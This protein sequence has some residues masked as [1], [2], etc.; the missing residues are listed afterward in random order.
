MAIEA[1]LLVLLCR[2][3]TVHK[4][5]LL[6]Q[7]NAFAG[8]FAQ[9]NWLLHQILELL[10]D[11]VSGS[12]RGLLRAFYEMRLWG[13]GG[14]PIGRHLQPAA[15]CPAGSINAS[16]VA[17]ASERLRES[18]RYFVASHLAR[19]LVQ[20]KDTSIAK[21]GRF[22]L[23]IH[24]RRGDKL[25]ATSGRERIEPRKEG[26][27]ASEALQSLRDLANITSPR[28]TLGMPAD[29]QP[30]HGGRVLIASDDEAFAASGQ[31]RAPNPRAGQ[32]APP[33][34]AL[35]Y[36]TT[37][38]CH[39]LAPN[40]AVA[41]HLRHRE[42]RLSIRNA[43]P[44]HTRLKSSTTLSSPYRIPNGKIGHFPTRHED[45]DRSCI[46]PLLGLVAQFMRGT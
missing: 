45:C 39:R 3:A 33:L 31:A 9:I 20:P 38:K 10:L 7:R 43:A 12:P 6:K 1:A 37:L 24:I 2:D 5:T 26:Q 40:L 42:P 41:R 4:A 18:P 30:P 22:A 8:L 11:G 13:Y 44:N 36:P 19:L 35:F 34:R 17:W 15:A 14:D 28:R 23:A 46:A 16:T 25:T 29:W 27:W 21:S 32:F